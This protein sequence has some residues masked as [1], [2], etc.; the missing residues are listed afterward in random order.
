MRYRLFGDS[1]WKEI[2][3]SRPKI[4]PNGYDD[5]FFTMMDNVHRT[6]TKTFEIKFRK[7]FPILQKIIKEQ[8]EQKKKEEEE[9]REL[10]WQ[11]AMKTRDRTTH[12]LEIL[13]EPRLS[14]WHFFR[15]WKDIVRWYK[16]KEAEDEAMKHK[17]GLFAAFTSAKNASLG[18]KDKENEGDSDE[19]KKGF[20]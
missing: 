6:Q 3:T 15:R 5:E 17:K 18:I 7:D 20:L 19:K 16:Q 2:V 13:D 14:N 10:T 11:L 12:L 8:K 4:Y 1:Y 9:L